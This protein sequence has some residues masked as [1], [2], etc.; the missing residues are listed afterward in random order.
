M[1][2]ADVLVTKGGGLTTAEA[3][4]LGIPTVVLRHIPGQ[5]DLNARFLAGEKNFHLAETPGA[6]A[7]IVAAILSGGVPVD[8]GGAGN[9][10]S[11][12]LGI[13]DEVLRRL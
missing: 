10:T 5:E 8:A 9:G 2:S 3:L 6:A 12:A 4:V 13:A 7:E 11:S 1:R